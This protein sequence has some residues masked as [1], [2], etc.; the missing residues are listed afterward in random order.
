M[1][2]TITLAHDVA[3]ALEK[4]RRERSCRAQRGRQRSRPRGPGEQ[5]AAPPFRQQAH[6][7]GNGID[8][9]N[10]AD[11]IENVDGPAAR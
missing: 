5:R 8:F 10:V 6:D 7:L 3:A 4:L 1:R 11:A 2:T 9:S